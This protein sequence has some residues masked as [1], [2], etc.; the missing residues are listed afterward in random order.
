MK[1]L[2]ILFL[3]KNINKYGHMEAKLKSILEK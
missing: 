2:I 1:K 3:I